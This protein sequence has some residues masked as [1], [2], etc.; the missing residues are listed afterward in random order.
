[1]AAPPFSG[2]SKFRSVSVLPPE[3]ATYAQDGKVFSADESFDSAAHR[4]AF[5][6]L[7]TA[8]DAPFVTL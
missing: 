4:V 2:P 8:T 5:Q 3:L 1:M 7:K 6:R